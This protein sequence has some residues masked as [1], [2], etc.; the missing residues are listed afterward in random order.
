MYIY[1]VSK[2]NPSSRERA[3]RNP[4]PRQI[5]AWVRNRF[6]Y[7]GERVSG[8]KGRML[9]VA[10]PLDP[11]DRAK[12]L[13]IFPEGAFV[14]DWR[15]DFNSVNGGFVRFV[16]MVQGTTWK[17]AYEEITGETL[18]TDQIMEAARQDLRSKPGA[19]PRAREVKID[20][21][22]PK[23]F[24]PF[25]DRVHDVVYD[26]AVAYLA[27]RQVSEEE[28]ARRGWLYSAISICFPF[29]EFGEIVYWQT[30][31]IY[32]KEYNFP[33]SIDG[34]VYWYGL[35]TV[36]PLGDVITT[37][38]VLDGA[39]ISGDGILSSGTAAFSETQ[40][41]KLCSKQPGRIILAPDNDPAGWASLTQNFRAI[42]KTNAFHSAMETR[43][44]VL[45]SLPPCK[46]WN[47]FAQ[48]ER[49]LLNTDI[50]RDYILKHA[51]PFTI[52]AEAKIKT[53]LTSQRSRT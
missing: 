15:P 1:G 47:M 52:S 41:R 51:Q 14:K 32:T 45:F 9:L 29:Y 25:K 40:V 28:A 31:N 13:A 53:K 36:E 17:Q 7:V 43:R 34:Q 35:D 6:D 12:K 18:T 44:R 49:R 21:D 48:T 16:A 22:L 39:V 26:R 42:D 4:S 37:E 50:V 33:E 19:P 8:T 27:R 20:I 10:N 38:G 11:E 30:R 46:D 2:H 23:G 24:I 3:L 5:E